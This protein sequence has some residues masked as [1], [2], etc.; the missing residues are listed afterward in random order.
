M[1]AWFI[2]R[3]L[4]K[5]RNRII[6]LPVGGLASLTPYVLQNLLL[7]CYTPR[8]KRKLNYLLRNLSLF[9]YFTETQTKP[10]YLARICAVVSY[11]LSI[12]LCENLC[13]ILFIYDDLSHT[14]INLV[15]YYHCIII[16]L[17][18][19]FLKLQNY[20]FSRNNEIRYFYFSKLKFL[21]LNLKIN[22][23]ILSVGILR[24]IASSAIVNNIIE[25]PWINLACILCGK[26][27]QVKG[28]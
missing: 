23:F 10:N 20:K 11:H 24:V 28:L 6:F 12:I 9:C 22:Y 15:F 14:F 7:F 19:S 13:N 17:S 18:L 5:I 2:S 21:V 4:S 25:L 27:V 1:H 26:I 8:L 16:V 3:V